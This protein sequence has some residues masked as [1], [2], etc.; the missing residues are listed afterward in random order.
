MIATVTLNP[1]IDKIIYVTELVNGAVNRSNKLTILPGGKGINIAV[2]MNRLGH[3]VLATGLVGG[4]VGRYI[5]STLEAQGAYVAFQHI[6]EQSRTNF[7]V[8]DKNDEI[9]QVLEQGPMVKE[10]E[11]DRFLSA[12]DR[13]IS[14]CE[15]VVIGG[16]CPPGCPP[17]IYEELIKRAKDVGIYT[18]LNAYGEPFEYGAQAGPDIIMP[19]TRFNPEVLGKDSLS[20]LMRKA[21]SEELLEMGAKIAIIA[22]GAENRL[23]RTEEEIF[24]SAITPGMI[25]N[26]VIAGDAFLAGL[27]DGLSRDK[28]LREAATWAGAMELAAGQR[29][30]KRWANETEIEMRMGHVSE[31]ELDES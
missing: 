7:I 2:M 3:E 14:D 5:E 18:A 23:I 11:I 13:T 4:F 16:T 8:V 27:L 29:L 24:D 15:T 6:A 22:H 30:E 19:D 26:T 10:D 1:A 9:T 20:P 12:Y 31:V 28:P 25:Q 17:D 21:I